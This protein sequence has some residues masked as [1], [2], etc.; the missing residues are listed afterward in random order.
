MCS[1][2]PEL[3]ILIT[4]LFCPRV[5]ITSWLKHVAHTVACLLDTY[6]FSSQTEP[7]FCLGWLINLMNGGNLIFFLL[8]GCSGHV[9]ISWPIRE[10]LLI[11]VGGAICGRFFSFIKMGAALPFLPFL[12]VQW[13]LRMSYLE[14]W[15][16]HCNQ[17]VRSLEREANMHMMVDSRHKKNLGP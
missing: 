14:P 11:G 10:I 4:A 3:K 5:K 8:L 13:L 1:L 17:E 9:T 6:S 2:T 15:Q 12:L 7:L 16:P